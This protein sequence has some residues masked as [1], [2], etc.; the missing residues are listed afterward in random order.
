[1]IFMSYADFFRNELLRKMNTNYNISVL[2]S[3]D[4]DKAGH[5]VRPDLD[6][7]CLQRLLAEDTSRLRFEVFSF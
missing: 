4:Q 6:P 1:M 5:S 2:N 3:L 7:N